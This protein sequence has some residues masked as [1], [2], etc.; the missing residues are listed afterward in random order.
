[1]TAGRL[2][3]VATTPQP[4]V[5]FVRLLWQAC[6]IHLTH[7]LGNARQRRLAADRL[8]MDRMIAHCAH[9]VLKELFRSPTRQHF[10]AL[11]SLSQ[12]S[13]Q[14]VFEAAVRAGVRAGRNGNSSVGHCVPDTAAWRAAGDLF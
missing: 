4:F 12:K 7:L 13:M 11:A 9:H 2:P 5:R 3:T 14:L 8:G 6:D 10:Q 1:M